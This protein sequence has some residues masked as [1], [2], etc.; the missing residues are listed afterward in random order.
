MTEMQRPQEPVEH[1]AVRTTIVGGR[2]PGCG[3]GIGM[4]PRGIEVL[5]KKA[6]VDAEF[7]RLLL[8]E[9]A[10][11]AEAIG[12]LLGPAEAMLLEQI[13]QAQLEL[14]IA[15]TYVEPVKIP[16]FLGRVAAAMLL[17]LSAGA[18]ITAAQ[19]VQA[20]DGI[21]NDN[22]KIVTSA[23]AS[24]PA[25]AAPRPVIQIGA[26]IQVPPTQP[27]TADANVAVERPREV[28]AQR[29]ERADVPPPKADP[30]TPRPA[31]ASMPAIDTALLTKLIAQLDSENADDRNAAHQKIT[32]MGKGVVPHLRQIRQGS[33]LSPE[34]AVR[35]DAIIEKLAGAQPPQRPP[36]DLEVAGARAK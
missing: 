26:R 35:I 18:G 31:A 16:A 7:R 11:A 9:R 28:Q 10:G 12:L 29:G 30:N 3:K 27:T 8:D 17:A 22:A 32:D 2:P 19:N 5:V 6:A 34:V 24:A 23:P 21:R 20:V 36:I 25:E 4:I 33:K 14:I 15:A 1:E 13:P